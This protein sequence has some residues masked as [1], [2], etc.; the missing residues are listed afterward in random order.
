MSRMRIAQIAPLYERVP[1]KLYGGTERV[2]SYLTEELVRRG[3]EVTLFASGDSKTGARLIPGCDVAL[4]LNPIVRDP[5]PY[6]VIMLEQV[7][8]HASQ[9]DILHFHI[10]YLHAPLVRDVAS[11]TVTTHHGRLDLP[12]LA[13]FYAVFPELP[14]VAISDDQRSHL[15]HANWVGTVPHGLPRDLLPFQPASQG[16]LAFLGRISPEKRPDLA[17]EIAARAGLPLKIAAKIDRADQAYWHGCIEPLLKQHRNVEFVGEI[18]EEEKAAFLGN[19]S[20]LLFPIDWPEPF[21]LVMVEAMACGTPVLAFRRGSVT[22]V[23][24]NG[25]SGCI[26][27]TVEEAVA[28]VNRATALDRGAVRAE[29]ERRFTVERMAS[30]Y[31]RIYRALTGLQSPRFRIATSVPVRAGV[32][33][34]ELPLRAHR[35]R[36]NGKS[37]TLDPANV[38]LPAQEP[39]QRP[40]PAALTTDEL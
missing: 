8:Q 26:I 30:D 7:R 23:L 19:A 39:A 16:Y 24:A 37:A 21:G 1:P 31:E 18:A 20:A 9:F 35:A 4:R 28:A 32:A 12:D 36:P 10:D 27:D 33:G 22:E 14:L 40:P 25:K 3:H 38:P 34:V 17:I 2:V 29:F 15:R 5:L 11:R 6:H 13:P